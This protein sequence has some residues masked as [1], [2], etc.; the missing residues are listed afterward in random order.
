M[1]H[2]RLVVLVLH[3]ASSGCEDT[4]PWQPPVRIAPPAAEPGFDP[5]EGSWLAQP[6]FVCQAG[7][8]C[9]QA[10]VCI[11]D[12]HVVAVRGRRCDGCEDGSCPAR[13]QPREAASE[14]PTGTVCRNVPTA[15]DP[16]TF[17]SDVVAACV[18]ERAFSSDGGEAAPPF[19]GVCGNAE[20][21]NV[22][23]CDD[24]NQISGDGCSQFCS[25]EPGF[26]CPPRGSAC[27][28][29]IG[30][31]A[32]SPGACRLGASCVDTIEV[33]PPIGGT[34]GTSCACPASAVPECPPLIAL[35]LPLPSWAA[36]C[37]GRGISGDGATVVGVCD[38]RNDF[39]AELAPMRLEQAVRWT[40]ARG[41]EVI[42]A[43]GNAQALA[44]SGDGSVVVGRDALGPFIWT[45]NEMLHL[46]ADLGAARS[47]SADG[48][49][50]VGGE[51]RAWVW[52]AEAGVRDLPPSSVGRQTG[53]ARVSADGSRI[54]GFE[55]SDEG[56]RL[57][58]L[59][60]VE[61]ELQGLPSP[62]PADARI[63]LVALDADGG[64]IVGNYS[65]RG[66]AGGIW[67]WTG[68]TSAA[69]GVN[70]DRAVALSADARLLVASRVG[71]S[72]FHLDRGA[73]F[74][75]LL[76]HTPFVHVIDFSA[77]AA[78]ADGRVLSG[79]ASLVD[80]LDR[81]PH[82]AMTWLP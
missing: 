26:Y 59:W 64:L 18:D 45:E 35:Q 11:D 53:A 69:I 73:A 75:Y 27:F 39:I 2:K 19:S 37:G 68:D 66:Q 54:I 41:A 60:G 43:Q 72:S 44:V 4:K 50:V 20:R 30:D 48:R 33:P 61:G 63:E 38:D 10:A 22:E 52:T 6:P 21:D 82:A 74:D 55:V 25:F 34:I 24:G 42:P 14:C 13:C 76:P 78:S 16:F 77:N 32:C 1:V 15:G 79:A 70:G 47:I 40:I 5:F 80:P 31:S 49:V 46:G 29:H 62:T 8:S 28:P 23:Q 81:R 65:V 36:R 12:R 17:P 58:L 51:T 3:V 7:A 9:E 57:P 56:E 71:S 67:S